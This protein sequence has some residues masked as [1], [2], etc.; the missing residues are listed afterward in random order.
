MPLQ[1]NKGM[2]ARCPASAAPPNHDR[3][4][5][6]LGIIDLNANHALQALHSNLRSAD[7]RRNELRSLSRL[8]DEGKVIQP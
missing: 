4:R 8:H 7:R 5:F 3:F 2:I 6:I 1:V